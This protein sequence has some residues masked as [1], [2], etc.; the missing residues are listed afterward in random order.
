MH[1]HYFRRFHAKEGQGI[2]VAQ[3]GYVRK[4]QTPDVVE[5]ADVFAAGNARRFELGPVLR[6]LHGLL[7]RPSD[8]GELV[9]GKKIGGKMGQE[10]GFGG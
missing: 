10:A 2:A 8:P 6:A 4:G 3:I 9:L 7:H 5:R 1:A